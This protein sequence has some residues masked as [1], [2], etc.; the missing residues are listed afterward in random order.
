MR[1]NFTIKHVNGKDNV[2]ADCLSRASIPDEEC[3]VFEKQCTSYINGLLDN[4]PANDRWLESIK[5][6]QHEDEICL[7][8]AEYA[9]TGWPNANDIP[10]ALKQYATFKDEFSVCE[11]L[12]L[13]AERIVIPASLRLEM[14]ATLHQGHFCIDN[15]KTS[16]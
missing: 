13:K 6:N 4:L 2:I 10:P 5:E 3:N 7:K 15:T 11:G 14:L 9:R 1:Y 8:I 16:T 12:L